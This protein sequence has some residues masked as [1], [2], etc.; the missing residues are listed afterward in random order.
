MA[1]IRQL[2]S[3]VENYIR[4]QLAHKFGLEFEKKL[5]PIGQRTDGT[6][7]RHEFDVVSADGTIVAAIPFLNSTKFLSG[8]VMTSSLPAWIKNVGRLNNRASRTEK[9]FV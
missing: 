5:L 3:D 2:T 4:D 7:A 1:N 8:T 6:P 9:G